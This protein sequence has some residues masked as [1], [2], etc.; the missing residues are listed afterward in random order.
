MHK[1]R[2]LN[3]FSLC[4][5]TEHGCNFLCVYPKYALHEMYIIEIKLTQ[6]DQLSVPEQKAHSDSQSPQFHQPLVW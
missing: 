1:V 5:D 3:N 2:K 6:S 4:F